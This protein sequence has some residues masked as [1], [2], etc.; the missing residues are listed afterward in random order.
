[1]GTSIILK[2]AA[3]LKTAVTPSLSRGLCVMPGTPPGRALRHPGAASRLPRNATTLSFGGEIVLPRRRSCSGARAL[4]KQV[5]PRR[6]DFV[7]HKLHMGREDSRM[8]QEDLRTGQGGD[9]FEAHAFSHRCGDRFVDYGGRG[10]DS[11]VSSCAGS[12]CRVHPDGADSRTGERVP[13]DGHSD[14][15]RAGGGGGALADVAA[16]RGDG[17]DGGRLGGRSDHRTL[18]AGDRTVGERPHGDPTRRHLCARTHREGLAERLLDRD[19]S[20][21]CL[22]SGACPD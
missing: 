16:H 14:H 18:H 21:E 1:M 13:Q 5:Y 2:G 6:Y 17:E 10:G 4:T 8:G 3:L 7:I 11:E 12:R 9:G 20:V 15:R 19:G 22:R